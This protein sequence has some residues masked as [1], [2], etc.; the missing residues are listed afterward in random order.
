MLELVVV[1]NGLERFVRKRPDRPAQLTVGTQRFEPYDSVPTVLRLAS[2]TLAAQFAW[3][4]P[5]ALIGLFLVR[6]RERGW[7]SLTLW[8]VW[9]LTYGIV[10]SGA[11]GIFHLYYLSTLAPPVAALAGIGAVKLW[12]AARAG[13][14]PALPPLRCGRPT[15]SRA[16]SVGKR[17]G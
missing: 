4:L 13:W 14:R 11:G 2:P 7:A 12:R 8:G 10:Y 3:F 6:R 15:C 17:P 16:R 9:V 5:L 1:H